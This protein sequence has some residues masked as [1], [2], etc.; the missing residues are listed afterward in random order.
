MGKQLREIDPVGIGASFVYGSAPSLAALSS[1]AP[2][3]LKRAVGPPSFSSCEE[4]LFHRLY[5]A[6]GSAPEGLSSHT[7]LLPPIGV[8]CITSIAHVS[9]RKN[10]DQPTILI[11]QLAEC[12]FS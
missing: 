5:R 3:I 6:C 9:A 11:A 1:H 4:R 7:S 10:F 2:Q 12:T 8:H